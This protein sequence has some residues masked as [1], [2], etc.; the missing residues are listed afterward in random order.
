MEGPLWAPWRMQYIEGVGQARPCIFCE[1]TEPVSDAERLILLRSERV[2]VLLNRFPYSPG[3]VMVA[4]YAHVG[5]VE[6]LDSETQQD[7]MSRISASAGLLRAHYG[8][9][10][11]NIGANIG[12]AGGAGFEDHLHFHLVPRWS[13]DHNFM[14]VV[15]EIRV[16]PTHIEHIYSELSERFQE[17][18]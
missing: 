8:C 17:L 5:L 6:E 16:I 2:F 12:R 1:P 7:L 3:H 4:P 15:G 14:T 9:D 11:L 10:G 13:G 18:P